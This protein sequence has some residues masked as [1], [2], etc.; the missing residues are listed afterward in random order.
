MELK[1]LTTCASPSMN[2]GILMDVDK[3]G[4]WLPKTQFASTGS[5][6]ADPCGNIA[7]NLVRAWS[8]TRLAIDLSQIRQHVWRAPGEL[9]GDPLLTDHIPG[10]ATTRLLWTST[11][12]M[13]ADPLTK[14]MK[15]D[16]LDSVMRGQSIDLTP[17]KLKACETEGD[18]QVN[19]GDQTN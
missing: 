10:D 3:I 4:K 16:G 8:Q 12:R 6:I 9:V 11:D 7:I 17:T 14:G 18:I 19:L 1:K 13:V 15:H 2:Y 5:L